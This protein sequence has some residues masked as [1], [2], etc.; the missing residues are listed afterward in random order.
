MHQKIA[1]R[2]ALARL[3]SRRRIVRIAHDLRVSQHRA[4]QTRAEGLHVRGE[5]KVRCLAVRATRHLERL[6]E[7]PLDRLERGRSGVRLIALLLELRIAQPHAQPAL[8]AQHAEHA[9]QG[10]ARDGRARG[11][12]RERE[13]RVV[14]PDRAQLAAEV[15]ARSAFGP[16]GL[17]RHFGAA[18]CGPLAQRRPSEAARR[19]QPHSQHDGSLAHF[20][21]SWKHVPLSQSPLQH[22]ALLEQATPAALHWHRPASVHVPEQQSAFA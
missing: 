13:L 6:R 3:P 22:C 10:R 18:H 9:V 1:A 2:L 7:L 16:H 19:E 8:R 17:E 12:G 11:A 21:P 4:Q 5:A 15:C 14:V 20:G